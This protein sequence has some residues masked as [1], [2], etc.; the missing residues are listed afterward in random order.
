MW[1]TFILACA[2]DELNPLQLLP[3][4]Y[5]ILTRA[6]SRI[7]SSKFHTIKAEIDVVESLFDIFRC[8]YVS[9]KYTYYDVYVT[10]CNQL[11]SICNANAL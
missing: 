6:R 4:L 7:N 5:E 11:V 9:R 3:L 2:S 8:C 10:S 1:S